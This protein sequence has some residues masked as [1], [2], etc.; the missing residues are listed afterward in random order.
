MAPL[1]EQCSDFKN[2]NEAL[3]RELEDVQC[4]MTT[5][6]D[7]LKKARLSLETEKEETKRLRLAV[8]RQRKAK[9]GVA[10]ENKEMQAQLDAK[11]KE[12]SYCACP[13]SPL[14][15]ISDYLT[16]RINF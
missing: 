9:D 13:L 2:L 16:S 5:S 14:V 10:T 8:D 11:D 1:A 7:K 4:Q 12:V 3:T 6:R 15:F